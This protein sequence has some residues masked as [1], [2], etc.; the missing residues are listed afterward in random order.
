MNF[1]KTHR[2]HLLFFCALVATP[3][4]STGINTKIKLSDG[5]ATTIRALL[6][7]FNAHAPGGV[8]FA[9]ARCEQAEWALAEPFL[10]GI[11]SRDKRDQ[12]IKNKAIAL[13]DFINAALATEAALAAPSPKKTSWADDFCEEADKEAMHQPVFC[14][15]ELKPCALT[16]PLCKEF[17]WTYQNLNDCLWDAGIAF[18]WNEHTSLDAMKSDLQS[19]LHIPDRPQIFT[20][21][22]YWLAQTNIQTNVLLEALSWI[23][24]LFEEEIYTKNWHTQAL[25]P[26]TPEELSTPLRPLDG[27]LTINHIL[28]WIRNSFD[29]TIPTEDLCGRIVA[30]QI[31]KHT[32]RNTC[33]RKRSISDDQAQI[34]R[35]LIFFLESFHLPRT[36][37]S[38][39]YEA[40]LVACVEE[41]PPSR[42]RFPHSP[43]RR[44]HLLKSVELPEEESPSLA[45]TERDVD[46]SPEQTDSE[47]PESPSAVSRIKTDALPSTLKTPL[48]IFFE[49]LHS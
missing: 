49:R 24:P 41:A 10:R 5:T 45:D 35:C 34:T 40:R 6:E 2:V 13:L 36:M 20:A 19:L 11:I 31:L 7:E 28:S 9:V 12:E 4:F 47:E 43:E 46:D 32:L 27:K 48:T 23:L 25:P 37:V 26:L 44:S 3:L 18:W 17:G 38:V 15:A 16:S 33:L 29:I 14:K 39:E 21:L 1:F 42:K 30:L 8:I 22:C